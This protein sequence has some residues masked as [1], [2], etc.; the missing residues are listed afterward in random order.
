MIDYTYDRGNNTYRI[1][2]KSPTFLKKEDFPLSVDFVKTVN[3]EIGWSTTLNENSWATWKGGDT[4]YDF[5]IR[6]ATGRPIKYHDF[7]VERDG[8]TIEKTL[9][10]HLQSITYAGQI[11]KGMVI[12]C[13]D[14][15]F[16]HWVFPVIH[17]MTDV[18]LVDG[19]SR[20]LAAAEDN[21]S[22]FGA[23]FVRAI[24]TTDGQPVQWHTGG[25]GYTD[26]V[27]KSVIDQFLA[28][29]DQ[30]VELKESVRM[31]DLV[32]E[33]AADG[34]DWLH[35]DVEGLDADLIFD[36]PIEPTLIILE[37]SHVKSNNQK[38]MKLLSWFSQHGYRFQD[39][40]LNG[41]AIKNTD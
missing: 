23:K 12:G 20:Q 30:L 29:S 17:Q 39:D 4:P 38:Y 5:V 11:P 2:T 36:L 15:L 13:H 37:T 6:T 19:S 7:D 3:G 28:D 33:H 1:E 9:W 32:L 25:E 26:T 31:R 8:D 41:L 18:V 10:Y 24:V 21:Y 27:V 35:L 16:G 34:L 14:G 22:R 40:G